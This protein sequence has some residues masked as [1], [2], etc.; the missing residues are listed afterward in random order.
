M[1]LLDR[2]NNSNTV[3]TEKK[4]ASAPPAKPAEKTEEQSFR[5]VLDDKTIELKNKVQTEVA[6]ILAKQK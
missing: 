2:L 5:Q 6:E 1:S 4:P 3:Q